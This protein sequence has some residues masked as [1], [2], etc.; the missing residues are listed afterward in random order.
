MDKSRHFSRSN[1]WLLAVLVIGLGARLWVATRGHNFD[2]TSYMIVADITH[3]GG[4]VYVETDRYNY[5]PVWFEILHSLYLLAGHH[6]MAFRYLIAFFLSLVDVGVFFILRRKFG[7]ITA[8]LFFLNPISIIITGFHSQFD[9]LAI[10]LGLVAVLLIGDEFEKPIHGKRLSG[11]LI[12]GLSLMTKHLLF[13]FPFWLAV[14][15]KGFSEKLKMILVPNLVFAF[16]FVPYWFE[17]RHEIIQNVFLYRSQINEYFYSM[18]VPVDIQQMFNGQ[19]LWLFLLGIFA[20]IYRRRNSLESLLLYTCLLVMATPALVNQ[21]LAIPVPFVAVNLNP[22]TILFTIVGTLHLL[23]DPDGLHIPF[24]TPTTRDVISSYTFFC[25]VLA[26]CSALV[27]VSWR[28]AI[29]AL[30]KRCV[31][32]LENRF[33]HKKNS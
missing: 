18:F 13:A 14:K 5:G 21:Y 4:N 22:F 17:G 7:D 10:L 30:I 28:Q 2:M 15:Q 29:I 25:A 24:F 8:C 3:H 1:C 16:G 6:M 19:M 33:G 31:H 9:N 11:L 12:L 23:F 27:W 26:L 20:F 32:E